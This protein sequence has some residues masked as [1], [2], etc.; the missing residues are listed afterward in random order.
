MVSPCLI[1]SLP[2]LLQV[3]LFQ[4]VYTDFPSLAH[5]DSSLEYSRHCHRLQLGSSSLDPKH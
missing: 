4:S 1:F 3:G 2:F 5:M